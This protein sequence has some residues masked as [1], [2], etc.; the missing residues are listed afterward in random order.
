M[1]NIE[2]QSTLH[3]LAQ[4]S[5][6]LYL[7]TIQHLYHHSTVQ[8][9]FKALEQPTGELRNLATLLLRRP[10]LAR[11]VRHFTFRLLEHPWMKT[12]PFV[13]SEGSEHSEGLEEPKPS[14]THVNLKTVKVDRAFK[15]A[16]KASSLS[17]EEGNNWLRILSNT[18]KRHHGL[19]LALLLPALLK[20][21]K[22]ILDLQVICYTQHLEQMIRRAA[23]RERPFDIQPPFETLAVFVH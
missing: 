17:K 18:H 15:T 11:L 14:E 2:S 21:Q 6:Q 22:L 3:K 10:D 9:E 16:V 20:L 4:C 5:H 1:A 7:C 13:E 12:G 8:E 19:V 23:Y